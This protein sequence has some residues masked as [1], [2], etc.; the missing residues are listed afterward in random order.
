MP[1]TTSVGLDAD[2]DE[3]FPAL[4]AHGLNPQHGRVRVGTDHRDRVSRL[5]ES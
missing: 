5:E 1:D 2:L 4:V 3:S